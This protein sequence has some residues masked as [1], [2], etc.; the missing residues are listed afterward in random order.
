MPDTTTANFGWI[1][2]EVG[3]SS[4]TWGTKLN[5]N[6]DAID[7]A[8]HSLVTEIAAGEA[9]NDLLTKIKTVD[10]P[11]SGLDADTLDGSHASAFVLVSNYE[12]NDVLDKVK[13][14]DGPGSGLDADTLDGLHASAFLRFG[15][16]PGEQD[17]RG[18][19]R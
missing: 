17:D 14:V 18:N 2:P 12:D 4:D 16:L 7:A 15:D 1:K 11:L 9:A 13:A 3:G 10:G 19:R 8:I 5:S 6:L